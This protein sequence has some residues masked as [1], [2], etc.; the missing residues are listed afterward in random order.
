MSA[1]AAVRCPQCGDGL[2]VP[3]RPP[4]VARC[5]SCLAL[6]L[7]WDGAARRAETF[8]RGPAP[9]AVAFLCPLCGGPLPED[10]L[11]DTDARCTY[12]AH[13]AE[14]P[15]SVR[16]VLRLVVTKPR[17]APPVYRGLLFTWLAVLALFLV[18]VL[19][20]VLNAPR[21][22]RHEETLTVSRAATAT[23]GEIVVNRRATTFPYL[24]VSIPEL[25]DGETATFRLSL[26]ERATGHA[27]RQWVKLAP[28]AG[29]SRYGELFFS[30]PRGLVT[31][32]AGRYVVTVDSLDGVDS[33]RVA[34]RMTSW[35]RPPLGLLILLANVLLWLLVLDIRWGYGEFV[36]TPMR[37]RVL[38]GI[39]L[40]LAALAIA[41]VVSGADPFGPKGTFADRPA[42]AKGGTPGAPGAVAHP[43]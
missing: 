14:L 43:G 17:V 12:C 21:S 3:R 10:V 4:P 5:R 20:E 25:P 35:E 29:G 13:P 33:A 22:V 8:H 16:E 41:V 11:A 18:A 30:D 28:G 6:S 42:G 38:R 19:V 7:V 2:A 37:N 32:H 26:V 23:S 39:A 27:R 31:L 15:P 9:A 40:A 36:E 1:N 24:Q 34:I